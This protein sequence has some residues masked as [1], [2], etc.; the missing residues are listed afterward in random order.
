MITDETNLNNKITAHTHTR[1]SAA[2]GG[3]S[4]LRTCITTLRTQTHDDLLI[5]H[6]HGHKPQRRFVII[7]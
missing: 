7:T 2:A 6:F 5:P 4:H 1:T 3:S